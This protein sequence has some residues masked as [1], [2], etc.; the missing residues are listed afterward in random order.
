MAADDNSFLPGTRYTH[1]D[2]RSDHDVTN[3]VAVGSVEAV[4]DAVQ[5]IFQGAYPGASF[6]AIWLAFHDFGRLF[7]GRW[8]GYVGCDTLYHDMQHTLDMTLT[9]ARLLAGFEKTCAAGDR[10]GDERAVMGLITAL[11]HD[12]GYIRRQSEQSWENGA[13]FT[14]WHVSRSADFLRDYLPRLGFADLADVA[15]R[16]VHFTGYELDLDDIELEQPKDSLIGHLLGTA[17]LITQMADRCYL[18]KCRDRLYSEFVLAGIAAPG[19]DGAPDSARYDSGID[20]LCK[21][22]GFFA[23]S[24]K[25]RLDRKFNRSYRYLETLYDGRNPYL[26]FVERN[27]AYLAYLIESGNWDA[28][29]RSPPC[30]TVLPHP[31]Q[32]VSAIVSRHLARLHAPASALTRA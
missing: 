20:L 13:E 23:E 16:V 11:F 28:L 12:S 1:Q 19:L 6:D 8:P 7:T 29:R 9:M 5:E 22:P 27:L 24:A 26:E 32:S 17:D 25:V 4:R 2:R 15:T 3:T 14:L 21:T 18:E 31:L 10:L 30:F